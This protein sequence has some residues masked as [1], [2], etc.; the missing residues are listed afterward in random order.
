MKSQID[1]YDVGL[2]K[3]IRTIRREQKVTQEELGKMTGISKNSIHR[4]ENGYVSITASNVNRIAQALGVSLPYLL[5]VNT[6]S[7]AAELVG[8]RQFKN[9]FCN[10]YRQGLIGTDY[11]KALYEMESA[12][13]AA[14]G[15]A[16]HDVRKRE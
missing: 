9:Y 12:K 13:R 6:D 11:E 16:V 1:A 2:G 15:N 8:L 10:L 3:R 5:A 7:E 4:I 14:S